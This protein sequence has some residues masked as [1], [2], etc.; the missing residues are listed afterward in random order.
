MLTLESSCRRLKY[1]S[2]FISCC[3]EARERGRERG[4]GDVVKLSR[5]LRGGVIKG[6]ASR[7]SS[8]AAPTLS[9]ERGREGEG[10][11]EGE[12]MLLRILR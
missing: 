5:V 12:G 9:K 3:S 11:G 8:A 6:I 2:I 4:R 1:Q 7:S 10:E